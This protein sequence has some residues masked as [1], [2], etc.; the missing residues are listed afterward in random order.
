MATLQTSL[1]VP[2]LAESTLDS[3]QTFVTTLAPQ[4]L[5]PHVGPTSAA[6]VTSWPTLSDSAR[7]TASRCLAYFI[8]DVKDKL[9]D[10]LDE[11]VDLQTLQ[12]LKPIHESLTTWRSRLTPYDRLSRTIQRSSSEN[13]TVA[14]QSLHELRSFML[15]DETE[16]CRKLASG[17][18]FDPLVGQLMTA[19]MSAAS[20]DGEGVEQLRLLAFEC[21]GALGALDPD[22]VDVGIGE[23]RMIVLSNFGDE[24]ESVL[25]ALHLIRDVLVGAFRSTSEIKYQSLLGYAIQELLQFCKF[26]VSLVTPGATASVSLK[27]RKAW[28]SLPKHVV[29]TVTPLLGA[30]FTLKNKTLPDMPHPIY[31]SQSTYREWLQLWTAYL[32]TRCAGQRAETI[33]GVFR[34][35][36]RNKDVGVAHQLLPHLVL[37]VIISGNAIE[38]G[39]I[40]SEMISVLED[41]VANGSTSTPEKRLLSAQVW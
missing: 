20:R 26:N 28:N 25:F 19:L 33:F 34:A 38:V 32:I 2:E 13:P 21:I 29:E 7:I 17:D 18:I 3:W 40:R 35:V 41:Q 39:R 10:H 1:S 8:L 4:D 22:R 9:G 27:T 23:A 14:I 37:N 31:P 16:F 12:E 30:R 24:D 36:V 11:I 6:I 15:D 5:G